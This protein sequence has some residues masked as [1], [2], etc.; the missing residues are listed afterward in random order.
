MKKLFNASFEQSL[1]LQDDG[2]IKYMIQDT[3]KRGIYNGKNKLLLRII[4]IVCIFVQYGFVIVTEVG[5]QNPDPDSF[6]PQPNINMLPKSVFW[7]F[8]LMYI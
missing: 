8:F 2:L 3:S 5:M 7:L 1:N 6:I 4:T